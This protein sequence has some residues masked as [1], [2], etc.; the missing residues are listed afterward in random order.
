MKIHEALETLPDGMW[1]RPVDMRGTG[2]A[3][4]VLG[5]VLCSVPGRK[6][7]QIDYAP[8]V[9]QMVSEWEIVSPDVVL[10]ESK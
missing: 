1:C 4:V 3:Y 8:Y 9:D 5:N 7:A 2:G 6:G 10:G